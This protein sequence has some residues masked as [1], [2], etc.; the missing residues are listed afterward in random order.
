MRLEQIKRLVIVIELHY[1]V[2]AFMLL[3]H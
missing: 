3:K 1:D 2:K